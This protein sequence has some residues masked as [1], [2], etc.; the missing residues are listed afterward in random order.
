M[1]RLTVGVLEL[2]FWLRTHIFFGTL[3]CGVV[4]DDGIF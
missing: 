2:V 3:K 1:G 4:Q